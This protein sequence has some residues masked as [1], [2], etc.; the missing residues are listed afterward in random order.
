MSLAELAKQHG[1]KLIPATEPLGT[2]FGLSCMN[3]FKELS[4]RKKA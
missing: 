4:L 3:R 1:D 2:P